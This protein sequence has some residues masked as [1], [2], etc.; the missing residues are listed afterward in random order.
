MSTAVIWSK[1]RSEVEFQYGGPLGEFNGMSSQSHLS[2]CRVLPPGEFTVLI[3]EPHS[4]LQGAATWRIQWHVIPEPRVTLQGRLT[5]TWWIHC[6]DPRATRHIAGC[7]NSIHHIENR[8]SPYFIFF[9]NAFLALTIGGFRIISDTLVYTILNGCV[10]RSGPILR[11]TNTPS[12][13]SLLRFLS[14]FFRCPRR[15]SR[16]CTNYYKGTAFIHMWHHAYV[17]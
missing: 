11:L 4:T 8:F 9:L 10:H 16:T 6:L 17:Q 12:S 15:S 5:A 14:A 1:S 3:P 2:H 7:K 13:L